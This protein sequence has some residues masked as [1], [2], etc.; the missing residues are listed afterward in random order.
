MTRFIFYT[1]FIFNFCCIFFYVSV[2]TAQLNVSTKHADDFHKIK[3]GAVQ[4]IEMN[5]SELLENNQQL[6]FIT[7][8]YQTKDNL[9]WLVTDADGIIEYNGNTF[10]HYRNLHNDSLSL[11]SNRVTTMFEENEFTIWVATRNGI[12]KFDR[13]KKQFIPFY[14]NNKP[15]AGDGFLKMP[16]GR[17]LCGTSTGICEIDKI[18]NVLIPLP[19]QRIKTRDG[20]YFQGETIRATGTLLYDKEGILWSN[21]VT[22]NLEGLASFDFKLNEWIFYPGNNLNQKETEK[23]T[24]SDEKIVTW[25]IYADEDADRIWAGGYGTGLRCFS[26]SKGTWQQ[27]YFEDGGINQEWS[28]TV[29]TIFANHKNELLVGTYEGLK[30]FNKSALTSKKYIHANKNSQINLTSAVHSITTDNCGNLWLGG[31]GVIR[32]HHLNNR[33]LPVARIAGSPLNI[34]SFL[35]LLT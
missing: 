25:C 18:N 33:F 3:I 13:I 31:Y 27:F 34:Q 4:N 1:S 14:F 2:A 9:I 16:D 19:N 15:L 6:P 32:L 24:H 21:I 29:L 12:C 35:Q 7:Q 11:T 23:I 30:I 22:Q 5:F 20:K 8:I 28:N 17:L 10:T 26:K